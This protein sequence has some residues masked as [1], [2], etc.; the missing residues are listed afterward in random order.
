MKN[1]T[2]FSHELLVIRHLN[3]VKLERSAKHVHQSDAITLGDLLT[4]PYNVFFKNLG[5]QLVEL[6][7]E[8]L[9]VS[10]FQSRSD[11]L[12][13]LFYD[14]VSDEDQARIIIGNNQYVMSSENILVVDESVSFVDI[15]AVHAISFKFPWYGSN[16]ELVGLFGCAI[17]LSC[18]SV[19]DIARQLTMISNKFIGAESVVNKMTTL[20]QLKGVTFT[21]REME[22]I[23][24]IMRGKTMKE[25]GAQLGLSRRTIESYFQNIKMKA[26]VKT[27]SQLF[28]KMMAG[29][30]V[31]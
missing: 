24:L 28:D 8:S 13:G 26:N 29:S 5:N 30:S 7:E 6:N 23:E 19:A 27:R 20:P 4:M 21:S 9:A 31:L 17:N 11:A 3:G 25:I 12:R 18:A 1:S 14:A 22:V 15:D 2:D 16:N 10:G